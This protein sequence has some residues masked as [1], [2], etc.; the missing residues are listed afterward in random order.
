MICEKFYPFLSKSSFT[1]HCLKKHIAYPSFLRHF[2]LIRQLND[3]IS[4]TLRNFSANFIPPFRYIPKKFPEF[5]QNKIRISPNSLNEFLGKKKRI[6]ESNTIV[7]SLDRLIHLGNS[8][9]FFF[10]KTK[11]FLSFPSLSCYNKMMIILLMIV[12]ICI[13]SK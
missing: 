5:A 3:S 13:Y 8:S 1:R 12:C 4:L 7:Y 6:K 9:I 11:H 2:C 10:A